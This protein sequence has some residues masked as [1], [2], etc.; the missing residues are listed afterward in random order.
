[1]VPSRPRPHR[2]R[3]RTIRRA[4]F[5]PFGARSRLSKSQEQALEVAWFIIKVTADALAKWNPK[6]HH[7]ITAEFA[8]A[9]AARYL[10]YFP[11]CEWDAR[12]GARSDAGRRTK[13]A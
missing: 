11:N 12:L 3:G 10:A 6:S 1:M 5:S 7:G 13:S 2:V 8:T 9:T 4:R